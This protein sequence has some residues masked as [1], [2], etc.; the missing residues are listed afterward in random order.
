MTAAVDAAILS[1]GRWSSS[2]RL[3]AAWVSFG[4]RSLKA[5]AVSGFDSLPSNLQLPGNTL[6]M[7]SR[8]SF[9]KNGLLI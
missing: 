9:S 7:A 4:G 1:T 8:R 3:G 2:S 5:A 6:A